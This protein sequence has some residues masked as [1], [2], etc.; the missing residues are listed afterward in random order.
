M[1]ADGKEKWLEEVGTLWPAAKGSVR[2][3]RK[4]CGHESCALCASGEKH[5]AYLLT[6]YQ[7]GKQ[8]SHHVPKPKLE[9]LLKALENGKELERLMVRSAVDMAQTDRGKKARG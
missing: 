3:V 6:Y 8:R 7:D 5:Q 9:A 2:E 4:G 1:M